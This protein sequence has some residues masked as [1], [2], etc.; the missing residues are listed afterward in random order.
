MHVRSATSFPFA[1][2][3]IEMT[4]RFRFLPTARVARILSRALCAIALAGCAHT[5]SESPGE[6][7]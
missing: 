4:N 1:I 5:G 2:R 7:A 6:D 3:T